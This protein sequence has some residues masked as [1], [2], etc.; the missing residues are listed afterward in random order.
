[1]NP[2]A[3]RFSKEIITVIQLSSGKNIPFK[4]AAEAGLY[5][6]S[7]RLTNGFKLRNET[8]ILHN[9]I[10]Y[11]LKSAPYLREDED[12][13]K[14]RQAIVH[15]VYYENRNAEYTVIDEDGNMSMLHKLSAQLLSDEAVI[16]D[17]YIFF[18]E[19]GSSFNLDE[20]EY[21]FIPPEP[22]F[23]DLI[24][25]LNAARTSVAYRK[26]ATKNQCLN[27]LEQI[28][29]DNKDMDV[30]EKILTSRSSRR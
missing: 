29:I 12:Y 25:K 11:Q 1:M 15:E 30:E 23:A 7:Q 4:S 10:Y 14:L 27:I 24:E 26:T 16:F 5:L 2:R 20:T 28:R 19:N 17:Q 13:A 8:H 3:N 6:D 21:K 22:E 18:D 9:G